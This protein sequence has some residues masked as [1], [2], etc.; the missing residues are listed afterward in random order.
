MTGLDQ[1][2]MQKNL[3]CRNIKEAKKNMFW[4]SLTLIPVN[5]LFLTLGAMLYIFS[6]KMGLVIPANSDALFPM[7]AT[8]GFMPIAFSMIFIIGLISCTYSSADSALTSL[9]TSFTIDILHAD[10]KGEERLTFTRQWVHVMMAIVLIVLILVFNAVNNQNVIS[11]VFTAAGYTY[12]LLLG[13][14][15][16]GFFTNWQVKDKWVPIVA[17][18][19]PIVSYILNIY[20][21]TLFNGY[22]FGFELLIMN[23]VLTFLGLVLIRRK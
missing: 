11:A 10:K 9:T 2:L 6:S 12:G 20:S 19:S 18:L 4:F 8:Q 21:T 3:S 5:L 7:I 13:M 15:A 1:D 22:Q 23:G 16:F 14:Y 17:I